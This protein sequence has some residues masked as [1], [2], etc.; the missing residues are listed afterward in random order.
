MTDMTRT[1]QDHAAAPPRNE[2]VRLIELLNQGRLAEAI[3]HGEDL[4]RRYRP[5][6]P[7]YNMLGS[8]NIQANR[9][10]EATKWF[11]KALEIIPDDT[12]TLYNLGITS[13]ELGRKTD[14]IECFRRILRIKPELS[15]VRALKLLLQA[16]ICDWDELARET[17]ALATLGMEGGIVSPFTM[18]PLEDHPERHRIRSERYS[19]KLFGQPPLPPPERPAAEPARL[20][21]GYFSAEIRNHPVARLIARILELHDRSRFEVHVYSYGP[22]LEDEMRG[23]I[24]AAADIFRDV[25]GLAEHDIAELARR[26]GIDVAIDLTGHTSYS[27]SGLFACRPA[28]VQISYLGYPGTIGAP[29]IDY[30]VADRTIIPDDQTRFYSEAPIYLPHVYQAQDDQAEIADPAPSRASLGL[31]ER[32]FVFCGINNG[33]KIQP[34]LYDIW[35]RLLGA[36]EGSVL[37]L[38]RSNPWAEQNLRRQAAARGVDPDRIVFADWKPHADYLAQFR[39]ADLFLDSFVYN[40]GATASN[41]LWAGLPV[42]T[43]MGTGYP[44]RM[45][46][47]LLNAIGLPD[48]VT[49]SD[50]DYERLALDLATSPDR[51]DGIRARLA[52]NRTTM[53]LFDSPLFTRHLEEAYRLAYRR[54]LGGGQP[55]PIDIAD[56]RGAA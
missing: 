35:M 27:R 54:W 50:E 12:D 10:A 48:L 36:V 34:R 40:A 53:P 4:A 29:C 38:L 43:R 28:P 56:L 47:S 21:I 42:V 25:P 30:I 18:L 1:M 44:A 22:V 17:E 33:Y 23:R 52:A 45:A 37:W 41:A 11:V 39:Q 5:S 24:M 19:A 3:A 6:P 7:L 46:G 16:H 32:G 31:P 20:R 2:I 55:V 9:R 49:T 14:A 51:L 13:Q 26:D 15:Q 8:A